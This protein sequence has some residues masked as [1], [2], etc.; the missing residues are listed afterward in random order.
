MTAHRVD[1]DVATL[2]L[3]SVRHEPR[4]PYP[5]A[6]D[7]LSRA[8]VALG[9]FGTT[10]KAARVVPHKVYQALALGVPTVT[11]RSPAVAEFFLWGRSAPG[12]AGPPGPP[13]P[14]S[15]P[16]LLVP[17]G[18]AEA[19]AAAIEALARDPARR[20]RLGAAGRAA[21]LAFA[22]PER[23]GAALLE[24]IERARSGRR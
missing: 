3:R 17:P 7:A 15:E 14:D 10:E 4:V 19:L 8:D 22:T 18:D 5:S 24:A 21:T 12:S 1:R 16:L 6:L 20:E 11:R 13:G 23:V 2:G 9:V